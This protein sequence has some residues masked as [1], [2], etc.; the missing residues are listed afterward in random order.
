MATYGTDNREG[1][2]VE[3]SMDF[4][5]ISDRFTDEIINVS[6]LSN[7]GDTV[8]TKRKISDLTISLADNTGTIWD[9]MGHGT[10]AFNLPVALTVTVGGDYAVSKRVNGTSF[11]FIGTTGGN[12]FNLHQGSVVSITKKKNLITIRS[13]NKLNKI[14]NLQWQMPIRTTSGAGGNNLFQFY[15]S[16]AFFNM[17]TAD[18]LNHWGT[19]KANCLFNLDNEDTKGD[20]YG[21][22]TETFTKA[23]HLGT[24]LYDTSGDGIDDY[25]ASS[26]T[27]V[28]TVF[29]QEN[30]VKKFK[31]TYLGTLIGTIN[32][33]DSAKKYGY[34]NL[35]DADTSNGADSPGTDTG[36]YGINLIRI[37]AGDDLIP[38]QD[39]MWE[40]QLIRLTG[41]PVAVTRHCLFGVMVSDFLD[42]T[43]DMGNTFA[44]SQTSV[45]FETY[46]QV[47]D[48][49]NRSVSS[50]IE[51]AVGMTSSIF[52]VNTDNKFEMSVYAPQDLTQSL[53]FIGTNE[54]TES[55]YKNNINDFHN[56]V[57]L[58]YSYSFEKRE[59]TKEITGTFDDWGI[60]TDNPLEI[61]SGWIKN[62][63]QAQNFVS[64]QLSRA[65]KTSPE[66]TVDMT[67]Q[68]AGRE[69]GS[70]I[71]IEDPDSFSGTKVVQIVGYKKDFGNS[72]KV[73]LRCLDGESLY[74]K[75]S[76]GRWTDGA[77][78]EAV[79][80][81]SKGG[82][83]DAVLGGAIGTVNNIGTDFYDG[84]HFI[85][86]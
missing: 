21:H 86:W 47:I 19:L 78:G 44:N 25:L 28:D 36:T 32:T 40:S 73:S 56:R 8:D 72:R 42:S 31:G 37:Q 9:E 20:F 65:K 69:L 27:H 33:E 11:G 79:D 62:D 23:N 68:G 58:K 35:D 51:D 74:R 14:K 75:R 81:D 59:H 22:N 46:D 17:S 34:N 67:L 1:V 83:G 80:T 6:P 61:E 3:F 15:G 57:T 39:D 71:T 2:H 53:G 66:I 55:S 76:Y 82:W 24:G 13:E 16:Y 64:R 4:N 84:T 12:Q 70:L 38:A 43:T 85:W 30:P 10:G 48:P 45:A 7:S 41:D 63:N 18:T 29:H 77:L 49:S 5:G 50:Y 60:L 26:F 54:I 52:F